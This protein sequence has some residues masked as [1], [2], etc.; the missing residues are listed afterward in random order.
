MGLSIESDN[1]VMGSSFEGFWGSRGLG[2][3]FW[4][5]PIPK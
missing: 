5:L 3:T 4:T 2:I 1:G